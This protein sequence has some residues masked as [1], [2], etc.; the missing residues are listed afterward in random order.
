MVGVLEEGRQAQC[1]SLYSVVGSSIGLGGIVLQA[2]TWTAA[3]L[4]S[5]RQ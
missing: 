3:Y 5:G 4:G 2:F 1:Y